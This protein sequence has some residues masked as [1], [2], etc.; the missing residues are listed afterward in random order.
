MIKN[1]VI[2]LL[3][4]LMGASCST[5][6][7][8]EFNITGTI[9][10]VFDGMVYLQRRI[11]APMISV[12]STQLNNGKFSFSGT[13]DYPE[14][15]YINIPGTKS[16]VPFFI[17]PAEIAININTKN[18]DKTSINGS[19]T[20]QQYDRYL[21]ALDQ[22]NAQVRENYQMFVKAK[23]IG[24]EQKAFYFD[25]LVNAF[26]AQ[27]AEFSKTY[28]ME[29]N[30][31]FISPYIT[32]RNS[33]NYDMAELDNTVNNFDTV[34]NNSVYMGLLKDYLNTLKR[35]DIGQLYVTFMMQDTTGRFLPI[36]DL[37][38][39][40]YLLVDF[41]ASWCAPCR[42]EN[43]N[44][45]AL[46]NEYHEKG[47]DILG[48]SFDSNRERWLMAIEADSLTWHHV[49]DLQG[50]EN[51]AGKLYGV[52]SIPANVLLNPSGIIIAK[53][54]RGEDLRKKLEEIFDGPASYPL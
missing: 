30:K 29:N 15:Y 45:V 17:E 1:L 26:D 27:R 7:K 28:V 23:E 24:D 48:V 54:L 22:F 44:L 47:F 49:S 13:V 32:Y 3:V 9:D 18:I 53:N 8:N 12:D 41:W 35:T 10:T 46:Y 16:L 52:R 25:S 40:N 42:E 37:T 34:L 4:V 33:W 20:Q 11:N 21:D 31:S 5:P 38:G 39:K 36:A 2:I 51:A 6:V 19:K 50:W 14:V 43:P